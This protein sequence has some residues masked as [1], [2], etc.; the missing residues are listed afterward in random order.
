MTKEQ[1]LALCVDESQKQ[2]VESVYMVAERFKKVPTFESLKT[3]SEVKKEIKLL[4]E[5]YEK[6]L[7]AKEKAKERRIKKQNAIKAFSDLLNK[8]E[9]A[10]VDYDDLIFAVKKIIKDKYNQKVLEEIEELRRKMIE[11]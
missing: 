4:I 2:R 3:E 10:K 7:I 8:A 11:I 6:R 9:S 5:N 1:V